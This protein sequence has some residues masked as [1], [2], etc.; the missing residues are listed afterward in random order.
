MEESRYYLI[1]ARYFALKTDRLNL[2]FDTQF[3]F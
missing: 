2:K 3:G 1:G